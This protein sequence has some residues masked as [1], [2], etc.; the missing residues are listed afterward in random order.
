MK[1]ERELEKLRG[2]SLEVESARREGR[3]REELLEREVERLSRECG[4]A[5]DEATALRYQ[6]SSASMELQ[7][8]REVSLSLSL[9]FSFTY[10]HTHIHR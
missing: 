6:L 3:E 2:C 7:Q 1:C 8:T 9:Y 10:T 5:R 4:V